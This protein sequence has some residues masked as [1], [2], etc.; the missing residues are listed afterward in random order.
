MEAGITAMRVKGMEIF[1]Q[2]IKETGYPSFFNNPVPT[3][4]ADAPIGVI[5]PPRL[6]PI[7]KPK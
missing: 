1:I 4:F 3:M 7:S 6:A 2:W 5:F